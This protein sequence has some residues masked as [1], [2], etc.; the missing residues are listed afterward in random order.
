MRPLRQDEIDLVE[1]VR[2]RKHPLDFTDESGRSVGARCLCTLTLIEEGARKITEKVRRELG[3]TEEEFDN[4]LKALRSDHEP[5]QKT[6][7]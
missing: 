1:R 3:I 7:V 2:K 5:D 4:L 6:P